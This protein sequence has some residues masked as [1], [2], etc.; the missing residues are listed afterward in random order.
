METHSKVGEISV[1]PEPLG[2]LVGRYEGSKK[3]PG[4]IALFFL[5]SL[6]VG[7]AL[8]LFLNISNSSKTVTFFHVLAITCIVIG[9]PGLLVFG[10]ITLLTKR[11]IL[12]IY[13]TGFKIQPE[14]QTQPTYYS[15]LQLESY[16]QAVTEYQA[17]GSTFFTRR[18]LKLQ[19]EDNKIWLF[20]ENFTNSSEL[21]SVL[22][23]VTLPA[24]LEKTLAK[25]DAGQPVTFGK[26]IVALKEG[27]RYN[28]QMRGWQEISRLKISEGRLVLFSFDRAGKQ[29]KF[30]TIKIAQLPNAFVLV[31]LCRLRNPQIVIER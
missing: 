4:K 23:S 19:T 20:T 13:K 22:A 9:L 2:S 15:W 11:N 30:A 6:L 16:T 18:R 24:L 14:G 10:F 31:E 28:N 12:E 27:L 1:A 7:L 8:L 26:L 25:L 5:A 17:S 29:S 3:I 21:A